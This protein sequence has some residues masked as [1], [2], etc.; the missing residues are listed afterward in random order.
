MNNSIVTEFMIL[1][2]TQNPELQGVLFIVFLCIYLVAFFGNGLII[3][4]II[5]NTTLHTPMYV[6][7]LALAIVDIICT[8]SIIPKMLGTMLTSGKSISY[9]SCMSQLF[10]FT[11]SLGAEMVLFTTMAYD[12]YVAICFP[13]RYSTIMNH[14]MCVA[15]LSIAMVIAVTNSWVHTGLI[16][17]LTFCGPNNIDHFFCEIPPLL[18]LSCS[19]VRIN[20]VMVYVADISLAIGD[21]S[22]TCLSYGFIIAAILRIRTAEGKRKAFSTCS[23]HL[24]V[25]S[26]YY[27]PVIYTYI[28]PASSYSFE[29]DKVIAALYT[30]V[31]PT[32]NPIVYSLRNKEMQTG[33][34]KVFAF[35]KH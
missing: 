24:I 7:L 23:S 11:W 6:F 26:L 32:L 30:L 25:V 29:R 2:L 3:I 34:Q 27:C 15:L 31:T 20:E 16:L 10:F 35:L 18:S 19:P 12:R 13:L 22:L 28:R 1:G 33:I 14:H 4:V 9:G 8:T 21:F 5:Y 17:N